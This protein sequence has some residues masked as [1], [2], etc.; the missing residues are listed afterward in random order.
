MRFNL[1]ILA[2]ALALAMA[3]LYAPTTQAQTPV[4]PVSFVASFAD[5]TLQPTDPV[6]LVFSSNMAAGD[7]QFAVLIG[8]EDLSGNF[9]WVSPT[10]LD[11][12]VSSL[13]W[14]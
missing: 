11:G 6:S 12:A 9:T 7:G 8:S 13:W 4:S 3:T 5:Q 1:S 14:C 10:Q 2:G